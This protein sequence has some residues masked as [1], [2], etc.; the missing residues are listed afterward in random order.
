MA[1][2]KRILEAVGFRIRPCGY[3]LEYNCVFLTCED[4]TEVVIPEKMVEE[5]LEAWREI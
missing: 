5:I 2:E 4:G 3:K 1:G